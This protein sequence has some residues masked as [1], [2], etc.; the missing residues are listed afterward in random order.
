MNSKKIVTSLSSTRF[1]KTLTDCM[2]SRNSRNTVELNEIFSTKS[3][4]TKFPFNQYTASASV[5]DPEITNT[6]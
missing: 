5:S 6:Q 4:P 2:Q 3:P 1:Y